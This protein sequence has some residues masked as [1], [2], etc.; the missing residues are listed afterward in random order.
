MGRVRWVVPYSLTVRPLSVPRNRS[1]RKANSESYLDSSPNSHSPIV[2]QTLFSESSGHRYIRFSAQMFICSLLT[3]LMSQLRNISSRL[4]KFTWCLRLDVILISPS[5][6][7]DVLGKR[8]E[9]TRRGLDLWPH[10]NTERPSQL[11]KINFPTWNTLRFVPT[12][13]WVDPHLQIHRAVSL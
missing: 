9:Y 1:S 4:R 6:R 8:C 11:S 12:N 3:L 7:S 13:G 2:G 10:A 5:R